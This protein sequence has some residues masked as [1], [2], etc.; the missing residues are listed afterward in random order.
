ML[1]QEL[2]THAWKNGLIVDLGKHNDIAMAFAHAL[3]QFTYKTPDTPVIMKTMKNGEW[4]GGRVSR[5]QRSGGSLGGRVIRRT[6]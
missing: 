2:E 4:T 1:L 6:R 5:P 3:D